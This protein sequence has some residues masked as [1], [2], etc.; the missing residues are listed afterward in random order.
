MATTIIIHVCSHVSR[1]PSTPPPLCQLLPLLCNPSFT[2]I[3]LRCGYCTNFSQTIT[4]L[5]VRWYISDFVFRKCDVATA[6]VKNKAERVEFWTRWL[7]TY[8]MHACTFLKH[9]IHVIEPFLDYAIQCYP[10]YKSGE[11][12]LYMCGY[13]STEDQ[14]GPEMKWDGSPDIRHWGRKG[15][16][17]QPFDQAAHYYSSMYL[18]QC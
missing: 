15:D 11:D 9:C 14:A 2:T 3:T 16:G 1:H 13:Y 17:H 7:L 5:S 4:K 18:S 12:R 6:R 10:K 8:S